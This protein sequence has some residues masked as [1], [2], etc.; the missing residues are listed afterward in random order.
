[1]S[2]KSALTA[3]MAVALAVG[4]ADA[5][6]QS[7][8]PNG[9]DLLRVF[10]D[11]DP[12]DDDHLRQEINFVNYVRDRQDAQV[13]VLITREGTGGGGDA[14]TLDFYGLDDFTGMDDQ[15]IFYTTQDDTD[16]SERRALAQML[17]LGL[18]RYAAQTPLGQELQV[19]TP[20]PG[21]AG[22]PPRDER[23]AAGRSLELLGLPC[24]VEHVLRR[25]GAR[26]E[27]VGQRIRLGQP[28]HRDVENAGRLLY[29]LPGRH[30]RAHR[31]DV[32][33]R[34]AQLRA[35]RPV[36]Q[37]HRRARRVRL[38][39]IGHQLQLPGTRI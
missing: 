35:R 26:V 12:C 5:A 37:E 14:W 38:R 20:L 4:V 7:S 39:R 22:C 16:A 18:V 24:P 28:R 36:R 32:H 25:R 27:T 13:H 23:P 17:R 29:Q 33:D 6:Q 9:A 19:T 11:C 15:L 34:P 10:L 31:F 8:E 1:M 2:M 30:V 21:S 3:L